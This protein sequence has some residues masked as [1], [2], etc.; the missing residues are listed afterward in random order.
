MGSTL[1]NTPSTE[2]IYEPPARERV[3]LLIGLV[4]LFVLGAVT[5]TYLPGWSI[6]V[7]V[8][9]WL[10]ALAAVVVSFRGGLRVTPEVA[11]YF[12]WVAWALT[13][14][15]GA[16]SAEAFWL[17]WFSVLQMAGLVLI[18]STFISNRKGLSICLGTFIVGGAVL[19]AYS[20]LTGEFAQAEAMLEHE[21]GRV[22][23][24]AQNA[25]TFGWQMVLVTVALA[26]FWMMPSKWPLAR[27]VIL[28]AGM[29][30][31]GA[32]TILSG[33]RMGIIGFGVF[34]VAWFWFCYRKLFM[35]RVG[36]TIAVILFAGVGTYLFAN[37]L[38]SSGAAGR[39]VAIADYARGAGDEGG[40][41]AI[42]VQ[43]LQKAGEIFLQ[44]PLTGVGLGN[45]GFHGGGEM[46]AAHSQYG[47]I[48]AETGLPGVLLYFGLM[49]VLWWRGSRLA[50]YSQDP[51]V[52]RIGGLSQ[53][54]L[55][56]VF[57]TNWANMITW[58]KATWIVLAG[59][60][61]YTHTVWGQLRLAPGPV[62]GRSSDGVALV[63][64]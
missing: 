29:L 53:A 13:G 21:A 1:I 52:R 4:V 7:K 16:F 14:L 28:I 19:G 17:A 32:A 6:A 55:L 37:Y 3:S 5:V 9:G 8:L 51:V 46:L 26:Y 2:Y 58:E 60:V 54:F 48:A 45:F 62:A 63:S 56:T 34:Y 49:V 61:G 10:L 42:R 27:A 12:A 44:H 40:G 57:V 38:V 39:L 15:F 36:V 41:V 43:L 11:M 59:F 30:G 25:N 35:R 24:L 18:I 22:A 20:I 31:T 50:K 64:T 23:G 33:S 47:T